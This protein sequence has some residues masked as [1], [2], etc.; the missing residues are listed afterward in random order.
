MKSALSL[1]HCAQNNKGIVTLIVPGI[2]H[3]PQQR[4]NGNYGDFETKDMLMSISLFGECTEKLLQ[5]GQRY[6]QRADR[7]LSLP[8][9]PY[10]SRITLEGFSQSASSS[11]YHQQHHHHGIH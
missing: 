4:K 9:Y 10:S 3:P 6:S 1:A 11:T 8:C 2:H 5:W 7:R